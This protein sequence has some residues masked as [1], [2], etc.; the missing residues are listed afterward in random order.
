VHLQ[1]QLGQFTPL[2][3]LVSS[4]NMLLAVAVLLSI[5]LVLCWYYA[6]CSACCARNYAAI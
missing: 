3:H 4:E 1:G 2:H 6:S 5:M